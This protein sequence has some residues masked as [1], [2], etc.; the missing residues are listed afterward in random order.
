MARIKTIEY[1]VKGPSGLIGS[2]PAQWFENWSYTYITGYAEALIQGKGVSP[3]QV[4]QGVIN[5]I[6]REPVLPEQPEMVS[7]EPLS[8]S[9][10][11]TGDTVLPLVAGNDQFSITNFQSNSN[12]IIFNRAASN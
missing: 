5:W 10:C 6:R 12:E 8:S 1:E 7:G 3:S 11:V 4:W 2:G 9:R